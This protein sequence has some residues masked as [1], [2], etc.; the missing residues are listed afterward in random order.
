MCAC[1]LSKPVDGEFA[2]KTHR[3]ASDYYAYL[4]E[5]VYAFFMV[6]NYE[7]S[8][9]AETKLEAGTA[10]KVDGKVIQTRTEESF[11]GVMIINTILTDNGTECE[12]V[13][14][15][16]TTEIDGVKRTSFYSSIKGM[17]R[18]KVCLGRATKNPKKDVVYTA[19]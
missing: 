18:G 4:D 14:V 10:V 13:G 5:S 7:D 3:L 2:E 6:K 15:I 11:Y 8:L 1:A 19:L 12:R 16:P 17:Y 9:K